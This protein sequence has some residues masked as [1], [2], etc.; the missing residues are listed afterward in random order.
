MAQQTVKPRRK[1]G[2]GIVAILI[3]GALLIVGEPVAA[4][5]K[6]PSPDSP[7]E[8]GAIDW[9]RDLDDA[10]SQ[11]RQ[12]GKPILILFQEVPGCA[13]CVGYGQQ[14]LS[15]PLVAD[16]AESLFVPVAIYN[17]LKGEDAEVLKAFDEP[18]WNNPVVRIVDAER[19]P[20]ADRVT[21]DY[22]IKGLVTAMTH[23]LK[24][25][26]SEIPLWLA[27]LVQEQESLDQARERATFAMHCFWE[28]EAA[29]GTLPGVLWTEPGF[30]GG[31]EVVEVEFDPRVLRFETL[32]EKA[33][34]RKCASRVFARSKEQGRVVA[35][36]GI[37]V[38]ETDES[39]RRDKEPKYYLSRHEL[40]FVPM[41]A[42]QQLRVNAALGTGDDPQPFLSPR[43]RELA[44]FV[45][46]HADAGWRSA[47]GAGDFQTAWDSAQRVLRLLVD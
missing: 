30:L 29:L 31:V 28:G 42:L 17:N 21:N 5:D 1:I 14:V 45:Q 36:Q 18:S 46:K 16:A 8:L 4:S 41:T 43:Q 6:N 9:G 7:V 19:K 22:S 38:T 39:I 32:L 3:A 33:A 24:Q 12:S 40:R 26:E 10:Q 11:A 2:A 27:L 44:R 13:T 34:Q 35:S 37:A 47:I 20:L 23:A 25:S 15:H